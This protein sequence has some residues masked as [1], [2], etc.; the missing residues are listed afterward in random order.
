MNFT[1]FT[2]IFFVIGLILFPF[3]ISLFLTN[4][5]F[6]TNVVQ[7]ITEPS[8]CPCTNKLSYEYTYFKIPDSMTLCDEEIPINE[9]Y[10]REMLDREFHISVWDRAQVIMWLKR[11]GRYFPHIEKRLAEENMPDDIKYLPVAES[12]FI[13]YVRSRAGAVGPW[14]FM[15]GTAKAKGLIK[16]RYVDERCS[17][18]ASTDAALIY[19]KEL[20]EMFGSWTL[21][22]AAYNCGET[23]LK[24]SIEEQ[25]TNNYYKLNLPIETERY[26]FRIAA[27]KLIMSNPEKYG[28][29][30][31]PTELYETIDLDTAQIKINGHYH[32][33][34][35]A[36]AIGTD[37]KTIK[38]LNPY[39]IGTHIGKGEYNLKV[40]K[41]SSKK[42][43]EFL[44]HTA[45]KK[46]YSGERYY[47]IKKGD[48][49][50]SISSETGVPISDL[51]ELNNIKNSYIRAGQK[52]YLGE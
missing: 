21:A 39:L 48:T 12:S 45:S 46:D 37:F 2:L 35:L 16:S 23:R 47:I 31:D 32:I 41:N 9:T 33:R 43:K 8:P 10:A 7:K 51:R 52:L 15:P 38:E 50:I 3:S 18:E 5:G 20:K 14:Q 36:E 24:D 26:I 6:L 22:M 13:I 28:Y 1:K 27:I 19:L 44:S 49:L 29:K 25:R 34:D 17:F 30:L 4:I 11:A 40:P 42:L